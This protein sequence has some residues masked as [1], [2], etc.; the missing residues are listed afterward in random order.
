MLD[1]NVNVRLE[2]STHGMKTSNSQTSKCRTPT[3][4]PWNFNFKLSNSHIQPMEW[5]PQTI[6]LPC[7][8][9]GM[10]ASNCLTL[11]SNPWNKGFKLSNSH[12]QPMEWRPQTIQLPCTTHGTK[13]SNWCPT[14]M[15]NPWNE[16]LKPASDS[17]IQPMELPTS[18][19]D[20]RHD[21]AK[22]DLLAV[23]VLTS[24]G[25]SAMKSDGEWINN[26]HYLSHI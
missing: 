10:K 4:N 13:T 3:Y 5:R 8:T 18:P 24:S 2:C 15:Y 25:V 17:H 9:H 11:M 12:I 6:W 14:P 22:H 16:D 19:N 26:A 1:S 21:D 20:D 7:P 23:K